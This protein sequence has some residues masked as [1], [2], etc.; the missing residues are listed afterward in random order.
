[1][2]HKDT[3]KNDTFD[4]AKYIVEG[5]IERG[6]FDTV[7]SVIAEDADFRLYRSLYDDAGIYLKLTADVQFKASHNTIIAPLEGITDE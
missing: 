3:T 7:R 5:Y 6:K 4:R 1:M 2:T